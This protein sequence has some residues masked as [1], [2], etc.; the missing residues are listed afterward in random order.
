MGSSGGLS[1]SQNTIHE[2]DISTVSGA[3][4]VKM[5]GSTVITATGS[6]NNRREYLFGGIGDATNNDVTIDSYHKE[7]I[8]YYRIYNSGVLVR[9]FI[10]VRNGQTGFMYDRV[11]GAL[12]PN[13]GS[14]SFTLGPDL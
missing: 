12:F 6:P 4:Y 14:G 2:F 5:D 13:E 9:D 11:T 1:I 8:Y 10:P 7:R 3:G